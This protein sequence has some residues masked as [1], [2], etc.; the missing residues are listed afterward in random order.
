MPTKTSATS[1]N[2]NNKKSTSMRKK[3]GSSPSPYPFQTQNT[4][5]NLGTNTEPVNPVNSQHA[6]SIFTPPI[7]QPTWNTTLQQLGGKTKPKPKSKPKK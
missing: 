3:G 1:N 6:Y 4:W 7:S 2:K 5:G